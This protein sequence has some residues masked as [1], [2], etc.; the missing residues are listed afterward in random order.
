MLD[1]L[2]DD[3]QEFKATNR[4]YVPGGVMSVILVGTVV[5]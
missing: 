1:Y 2:E 4:R 5:S 3:I